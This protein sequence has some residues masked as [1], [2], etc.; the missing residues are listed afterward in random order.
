[1]QLLS[2]LCDACTFVGVYVMQAKRAAGHL[3][4]ALEAFDVSVL[5]PLSRLDASH[6]GSSSLIPCTLVLAQIRQTVIVM[7]KLHRS[8][9]KVPLQWEVDR[10]VPRVVKTAMAGLE[11]IIANG[12]TNRWKGIC[13]SGYPA[14]CR[15]S[16]C[17]CVC[18]CVRVCAWVQ[19]QVL[20]A[21]GRAHSRA[22][23]AGGSN[24]KRVM[25]W[26]RMFQ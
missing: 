16:R 13:L 9:A 12:L 2:W 25:L 23:R 3:N 20:C 11:Q 24:G 4:F 19:L 10:R 22:R 1:M 5:R 17:E 6:Y 26:N 15:C 18:V 14:V 8:F 21:R 7:V